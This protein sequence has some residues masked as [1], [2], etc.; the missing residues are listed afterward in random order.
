[1]TPSENG[2]ALSPVLS[3]STSTSNIRNKL[4]QIV[5]FNCSNTVVYD[6]PSPSDRDFCGRLRR[7]FCMDIPQ[8]IYALKATFKVKA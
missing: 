5:C 1:M 3:E 2:T 7:G 4:A 8:M 6:Y